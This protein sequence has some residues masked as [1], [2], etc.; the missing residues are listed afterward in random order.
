MISEFEI[1]IFICGLFGALAADIIKDNSL[2]LPRFISGRFFLGSLGGLIV[3]G[4]AGLAIDGSCLTAFMGGF[5]G[6]EIITSLIRS[7]YGEL[8]EKNSQTQHLVP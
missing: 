8:H 2:E 1:V 5:M 6:K 3:G 7:K 4:F